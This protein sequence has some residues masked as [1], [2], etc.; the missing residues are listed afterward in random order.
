LR[1]VDVAFTAVSQPAQILESATCE[2]FFTCLATF[3]ATAH[4]MRMRCSPEKGSK[5]GKPAKPLLANPTIMTGLI[6]EKS[7]QCPETTLCLFR[8]FSQKKNDCEDKMPLM[9][10]LHAK[11]NARKSVLL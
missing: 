10:E 5:S 11:E 6:Q 1:K 9:Q 2:V 7:G 4:G 3:V 8:K